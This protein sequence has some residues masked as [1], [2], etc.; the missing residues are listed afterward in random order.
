MQFIGYQL[1]VAFPEVL[2]SQKDTLEACFTSKL[3]KNESLMV[4][5]QAS[6]P[7]WWEQDLEVEVHPALFKIML[8]WYF[9]PLTAKLCPDLQAAEKA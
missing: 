6:V 1:S 3:Q 7:G 9:I 8:H 5:G 4:E 2:A